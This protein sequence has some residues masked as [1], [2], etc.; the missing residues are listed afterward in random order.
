MAAVTESTLEELLALTSRGQEPSREKLDSRLQALSAQRSKQLWKLV[1]EKLQHHILRVIAKDEPEDYSLLLVELCQ[2][3][4]RVDIT[5]DCS[6]LNIADLLYGL[7]LL[8]EDGA[9]SHA[10]FSFCKSWCIAKLKH[11]EKLWENTFRLALKQ[12]LEQH[13]KRQTMELVSTV[14]L[15]KDGLE[16]DSGALSFSDLGCEQNLELKELLVKCS[17]SPTYLGAD[18]GKKFVSYLLT[19][20]DTIAHAI[21]RAVKSHLCGLSC[22]HVQALALVYLSAWKAV[23]SKPQSEVLEQS[24]QDV[25]HMAVNGQYTAAQHDRLFKFLAIFH[26]KQKDRHLSAMLCRNYEPILWRGLKALHYRV[27]VAAAKIFFNVFPLL[28]S[29]QKSMMEG[30]LRRDFGYMQCLLKDP[31]PAVRV[32][33]VTG[34]TRCLSHFYEL[35]PKREKQE[36]G[37]I[38][39]K[40]NAKDATSV[41]SRVKVNEGLAYM[42]RNV[43]THSLLR[44][45]IAENK[46]AINDSTSVKKSYISLLLKS[47]SI[48]GFK[49]WEVVPLPDLLRIMS[50][51]ETGTAVKV[52]LLLRN[53]YFNPEAPVEQHLERCIFLARSSQAAFQIF[54]R[55]LHK[56]APLEKIVAFLTAVCKVLLR[57]HALK[58][59]AVGKENVL[60]DED[61]DVSDTNSSRPVQ[62]LEKDTV[63][64]LAEVLAVTYSTI[65]NKKELIRNAK[66]KDSWKVLVG[67]MSKVACVTFGECEEL[68]SKLSALS[69]ASLVSFESSS[70]LSSRC[71][72]LLRTMLNCTGDAPVLTVEAKSCLVFLCNMK[73]SADVLSRVAES[74]NELQEATPRKRRRVRFVVEKPFTAGTGLEVLR[75]LLCTPHLQDLLLTKHLLPL[76][77]IWSVLFRCAESLKRQLCHATSSSTS[78]LVNSYELFLLLTAILQGQINPASG[79]KLVAVSTLELQ[80][81]WIKDSL[82]PVIPAQEGTKK[83]L[84][85]RTVEIYLNAS[86]SFFMMGLATPE[87]AEKL[88][89][90]LAICKQSDAPVLVANIKPIGKAILKHAKLLAPAPTQMASIVTMLDKLKINTPEPSQED[91]ENSA[92]AEEVPQAEEHNNQQNA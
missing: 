40:K 66:L 42:V 44:A 32:V 72:S 86:K 90:L 17:I 3:T 61:E 4:S 91:A 10:I 30:E 77:N 80:L 63:Q 36:L 74:L 11:W 83:A 79:A 27:R 89:S 41:E 54:Y 67:S 52:A 71:F 47:R 49:F 1:L 37:W 13:S 22:A 46:D 73:R 69:V 24:I 2:A 53:S 26:S 5:S 29:S 81:L 62:C 64:S 84:S 21:F 59:K 19:R 23:A 57:N 48:A 25:M 68:Q 85:I 20:D 28:E 8:V 18:K 12:S 31:S 88:I 43:N 50:E 56:I 6:V 35:F 38:L 33:A 51:S 16:A 7:L 75:Y 9:L 58:V 34:V 92:Q 70:S 45:L 60:P 82:V 65:R 87:Y 15:L 39:I 76:F 78:V 14:F 55:M